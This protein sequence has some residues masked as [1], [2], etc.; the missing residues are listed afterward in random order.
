MKKSKLSVIIITKNEEKNIERCL[1][2]VK[3]ADEIIVVDSFSTDNTLNIVEKYTNNVYQ[4]KWLG[5]ANQRNFGVDQAKNDWILC[6][7]S[8]EVVTLNLYKEIKETL[9][10]TPHHNGYYIPMKN[11]MFTRW[12]KYSG[13]SK[14]YH[15][16]LYN[17][18]K[19][20][21]IKDIHEIVKIEGDSGYLKN[22]IL[23]YAY[24]SINDLI[25][26]IDVYTDLEAKALYE[27]NIKFNK[28]K[29]LG[30]PLII[31]I[32][33]YIFQKGFL[34]GY[35]GLI[36][37]VSLAYYNFSKWLKVWEIYTNGGKSK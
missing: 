28:W 26:K 12:M 23:H 27:K 37:A 22:I 18:H 13:L 5:Y 10:S 4:A 17:K 21:W 35:P 19:G 7:D 31:F 24:I 9:E 32:Y 29:A 14:Q 34:D 36:W 33:K 2:S 15:L 11:F 6:I 8:D 30:S 3:W 20:K 25:K 16:R 1:K